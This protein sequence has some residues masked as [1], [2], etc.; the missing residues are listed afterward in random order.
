MI[1]ETTQTAAKALITT[2]TEVKE[3]LR[4]NLKRQKISLIQRLQHL[5]HLPKKLLKLADLREN[6]VQRFLLM[7]PWLNLI[8]QE[9]IDSPGLS[10]VP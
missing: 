6:Q 8:K 2:T 9:E 5:R 3:N 4:Q 7:F 10:P 1:K